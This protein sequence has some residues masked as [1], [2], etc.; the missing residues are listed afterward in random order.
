MGFHGKKICLNAILLDEENI[1]HALVPCYATEKN[2]LICVD[3][4]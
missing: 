4:I 3:D 2:G 1:A